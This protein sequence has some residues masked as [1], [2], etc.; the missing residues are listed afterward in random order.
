MPEM[1]MKVWLPK[2]SPLRAGPCYLTIYRGKC[3]AEQGGVGAVTSPKPAASLA[4]QSLPH[5][6]LTQ[7]VCWLP[8]TSFNEMKLLKG[9]S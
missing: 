8:P 2:A 5:Q 1:Q 9:S 7:E 4:G 3:F 6:Q